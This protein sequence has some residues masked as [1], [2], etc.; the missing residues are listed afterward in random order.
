MVSE[1]SKLTFTECGWLFVE[2][3]CGPNA[4]LTEAART[5]RSA[6]MEQAKAKTSRT[7]APKELSDFQKDASAMG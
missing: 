5:A 6:L 3:F 2:F 4:P 7:D 1:A